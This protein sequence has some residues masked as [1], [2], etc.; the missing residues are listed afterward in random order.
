MTWGGADAEGV[1]RWLYELAGF[2]EGE[3]VGPRK[4]AKALGVGVEVAPRR[5][6]WKDATMTTV[7][8]KR[9][10][11]L[12]PRLSPERTTFAIC[13]ELAEWAMAQRRDEGIEGLADA[14]AAAI[15]APRQLFREALGALG[16]DLPRLAH[17]FR[18]TETCVALRIGEVTAEPVALVSPQLVRVR[19]EDWC[20]P[21]EQEIRRLSRTDGAQLLRVVRLTDDSRRVFLRAA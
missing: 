17:E 3:P 5:G 9:V 21:G 19:G 8:G 18:T 14:A 6:L 2:S 1:A 7:L 16:S 13:H 12:A 10:I 15:L 20:W 11:W 4:L